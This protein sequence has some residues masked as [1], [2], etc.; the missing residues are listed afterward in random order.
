M[1]DE[2]GFEGLADRSNWV[3]LR[4]LVMLRWMAICGQLAAIFVA[5]TYFDLAL[6]LP[7]ALCLVGLSA[8]ANVVSGLMY[9]ETRRLSEGEALFLL[10]FDCFQLAA[11]LFLS[12]GLT[13]P[14]A[15]LFL[16]P[17]TIAATALERRATAIVVVLTLVL[18]TFLAIAH[19]PLRL[20]DGTTITV[21]ALFGFG[22]W[23]AIVTGVLFL[24]LY[25]RRVSSELHAMSD[26][27]MATQM[28]LAREQKLTDLSGVVAAAAHELGTPLATIKLASSELADELS[29]RADLRADAELIR[30]QADRCRDILRSMGRAGKDDLHMRA[31]PFASVIQEAAEPHSHRKARLH[32]LLPIDGDRRQPMVR[33]RPEIIHGLRNLVQ[34]AVDFAHASVWIDLNWNDQLL[35]MTITDDGPGFPP[36]VLGRIGDPFMRQ[37]AAPA[38]PDR[39][40]YEGMGLGLFI[41]KTLLERT[42]AT[43]VFANAS[44]PFLAEEER[45]ARCGAVVTVTWPRNSIEAHESELRGQNVPIL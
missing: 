19:I 38:D 27:L 13:N 26:A 9:P 5:S 42:G 14:F 37:R 31:A 11:L 15:L 17:A 20:R 16:A 12:G 4:T 21:P 29:D 43:L 44:D 32:L 45:T 40:H 24:A 18:V 25:A 35:M 1:T 3:R 10:L 7:A 36:A 8:L 22:F 30:D 2:L 23:L 6:N 39:P 41:A 33:R 28:A 34:N